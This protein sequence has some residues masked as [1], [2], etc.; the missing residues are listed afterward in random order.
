[1]ATKCVSI[2]IVEDEALTREVTTRYLEQAGF[3][4]RYATTGEDALAL[5]R[6][7]G[8]A[9]DHLLTDINLPGSVDGWTVGAEFHLRFPLRPVVYASA[10]APRRQAH[11]AGGVF[12]S[13]PYSPAAMV[14]VFQRL[15]AEVTDAPD[16]RASPRARSLLGARIVFGRQFAAMECTMRDMSETGARLVLAGDDVLPQEFELVVPTTGQ[17]RRAR[18]VWRREKTCGVQFLYKQGEAGRVA[19]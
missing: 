17:R 15:T 7:E 9:I 16:L 1:M 6:Q 5:L 2:L 10:F 19:A 13:K 14:E 11:P 8:D 12:V 3:T 4:V 18:L